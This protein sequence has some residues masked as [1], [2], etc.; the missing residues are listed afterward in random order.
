MN[1]KA[2]GWE[3]GMRRNKKLYNKKHNVLFKEKIIVLFLFSA[4]IK[5]NIILD[6]I[7]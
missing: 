3:R 2:K 4:E 5:K 7:E 6:Q 1:T